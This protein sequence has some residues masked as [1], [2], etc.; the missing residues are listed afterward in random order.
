MNNDFSLKSEI[1]NNCL[2]IKT[3]GYVNNVGGETIVKE[4]EKYFNNGITNVVIDLADS[5]VVNSIGISYLLEIIEQ[6]IE[7]KGKLVFTSM[8][9]AIDKSFTIMGMFHFAEKAD[10]VEDAMKLIGT[11]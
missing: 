3:S 1:L 7:K 9:S 5:K 6:L 2:V 10:S 4:F 11:S 8:D